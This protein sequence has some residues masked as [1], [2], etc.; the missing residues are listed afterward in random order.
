MPSIPH[1]TCALILAQ[2]WAGLVVSGVKRWELRST[3]C[4]KR[5][6][7]GIIAKGSGTVIGS[8][9]ITGSFGPMTTDQLDTTEDMHRVSCELRQLKPRWR[10]AWHF[11]DPVRF[12][13]PQPYR[14]PN[15]A[16]SW[17]KL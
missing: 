8:V 14:H 13:V 9:V 3:A 16:Q 4:H 15:G 1:I 7:V 2:P 11:A 6:R 5:E 10:H 12:D 17:I